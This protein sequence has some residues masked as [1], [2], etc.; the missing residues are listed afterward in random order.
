MPV[1]AS[2]DNST[3]TALAGAA[4]ALAEGSLGVLYMNTHNIM[5]VFVSVCGVHGLNLLVHATL[6][7]YC[8]RP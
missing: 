5:S 6:S 7:Y 2:L 8:M 3:E 1:H 4:R